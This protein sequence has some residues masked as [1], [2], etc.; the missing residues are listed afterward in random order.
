MPQ[1]PQPPQ[2]PPPDLPNAAPTETDPPP[3][4][5]NKELIKKIRAE[6]RAKQKEIREQQKERTGHRPPSAILAS[7]IPLGNCAMYDPQDRLLCRCDED[8]LQW[9]LSRDL[10]D[11]VSENPRAIKLRFAPKGTGHFGDQFYMAVHENQCAVCGKKET[12]TKHHVIAR[13]YRTH[14]PEWVKSRSS[15]DILLLCPV[16]HDRYEDAAYH[17]RL[18]L[19]QELGLKYDSGVASKLPFGRYSDETSG[20]VQEQ[21]G[22]SNRDRLSIIFWGR[23]VVNKD[24]QQIIS[25]R[26]P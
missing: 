17:L 1:N 6:R 7:A 25:A 20:R 3:V 12:L 4:D 2:S 23:F 18:T 15:H 14:M 10:A 21:C 19:A 9:Y 5:S 22:I 13:E 8:K 26:I 24:A 11:L 16:C